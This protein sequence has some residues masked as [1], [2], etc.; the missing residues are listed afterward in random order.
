ME[1]Q[2]FTLHEPNHPM[3]VRPKRP[4][5]AEFLAIVYRRWPAPT[6][7]THPFCLVDK[8]FKQPNWPYN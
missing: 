5:Q 3:Q 2:L 1:I 7:D 4:Y 8:G 6:R